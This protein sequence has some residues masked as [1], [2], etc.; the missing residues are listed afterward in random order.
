[1]SVTISW[2]LDLLNV[3]KRS[4]ET[5]QQLDAS[6]TVD[7]VQSVLGLMPAGRSPSFS[8]WCDRRAIL[9]P[10]PDPAGTGPSGAS[11]G[12]GSG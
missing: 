1:M 12:E 10:A 6:Y 11:L 2:L 5:D 7:G 3:T 4:N 9:A 8:V